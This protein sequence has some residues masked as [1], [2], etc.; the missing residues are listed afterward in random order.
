[1]KMTQVLAQQEHKEGKFKEI[2]PRQQTTQER[3]FN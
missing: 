3:L 1:M 2:F